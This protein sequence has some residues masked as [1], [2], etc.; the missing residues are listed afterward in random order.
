PWNREG[1][2]LDPELV[3]SLNERFALD[4]PLPVQYVRW[5]WGVL[6]GDFG[7]SYAVGAL[8]GTQ[9]PFR[10][11]TV[12]V[13]AIIGEA[14]VPSLQLATL[15]FVLAVV[16]G[17]GL[18]VL[19]AWHHDTWVD[20]AATVV[21]LLGMAGPPFLLAIL[22]RLAF[23]THS[24][25]DPG[26]LPVSGWETPRHWVLPTMALAALPAAMFARF[27]RASVL[28]VI[29]EG[30]VRTAHSKGLA[31]RR[32]A[33]VHV[34]RNALIPVAAILGPVLAVLITGTIVIER[35]FE[36]PGVGS[37]Y[38]L[39]ITSRDYGVIMSITLI[40]TVAIA[41]MNVLVDL[42]YGVIDPRIRE[43]QAVA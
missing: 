1:R 4:Q 25:R 41:G 9:T 5:L 12:D 32:I 3:A 20:H 13:A 35:V 14:F 16:V 18:G 43:A 22:L 28:E 24:V 33:L 38:L 39:A 27:T 21:A 40:Y 19:A 6:N 10:I 30:Y 15:A 34:L 8:R 31:P 17:V 2:Q 11:E 42:V 26:I 37:L 36:I 23:D 29:G 7:T